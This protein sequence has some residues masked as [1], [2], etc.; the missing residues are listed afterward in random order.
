MDWQDELRRLDKQLSGGEISAQD[1]RR[2]RDELLAEASAPAQGR[3][4]LWSSARPDAAPPEAA[5]A[6]PA[7]PAPPAPP[8]DEDAEETQI[9]AD[10]TVVVDETVVHGQPVEEDDTAVHPAPVE[11]TIVHSAPADETAVHPAPVEETVVQRGPAPPA[12]PRNAMESTET[13]A[14]PAARVEPAGSAG[15]VGLV[16]IIEPGDPDDPDRTASV[17]AET[18]AESGKK[19]VPTFPPRPTDYPAPPP[20]P[21]LPAPARW[22]GHVRGEEVFSR[23]RPQGNA[24]RTA[25]VLLSVVI[26]LAVVGGGVWYFAFRSDEAPAANPPATSDQPQS[27]APNQPAPSTPQQS[28]P[29]D[30]LPTNL[31]DVVGP[32]PG[33]ADKNN[34]TISAARAGQLKLLAPQ[35][36]DA[37]IQSSVSD[38][39]FRGSTKGETGNA[40]LVFTMPNATTAAAFTDAERQYLG[41]AGFT[42]GKELSSGLPVLERSEEATVY[43]VVYTTGKYTVRFGVAQLNANRDQLRRELETVADTILAVLPP[44]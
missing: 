16:E 42:P 21:P 19:K 33:A 1:Y 2:M 38:V 7:P 32:L 31:A 22:T 14:E 28:T 23:A 43:R 27:Q 29:P 41:D 6:T 18:V 40:L 24:R 37:A 3:G 15:S 20:P 9:V 11:E 4:S 39:I 26:A 25:A 12:A 30:D 10:E 35:E 8:A 34:G 5:P 36:V 17:A 13:V 44:S